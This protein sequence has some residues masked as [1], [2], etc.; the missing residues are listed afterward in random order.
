MKS[1]QSKT[2]NELPTRALFI[3]TDPVA[4]GSFLFYAFLV[5]EIPLN[6]CDKNDTNYA[7]SSDIIIAINNNIINNIINNINNNIINVIVSY[8]RT[9]S[10]Y[11]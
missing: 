2:H 4:A 9:H 1:I 7:I 11:L 6:Q 3:C 10:H 8:T 5:K